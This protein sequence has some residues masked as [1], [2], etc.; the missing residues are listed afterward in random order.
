MLPPGQEPCDLLT[1]V[2]RNNSA[3]EHTGALVAFFAFEFRHSHA[4]V[5]D[6]RRSTA[7]AA[8]RRAPGPVH[9]RFTSTR[10]RLAFLFYFPQML[11]KV[12]CQWIAEKLFDRPLRH[13]SAHSRWT[14]SRG[15]SPCPAAP[16]SPPDSR[17]RGIR[18]NDQSLRLNEAES[19]SLSLRL[20]NL[21]ARGFSISGFP[22]RCSPASC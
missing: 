9:P 17:C 22:S 19:S 14:V 4:G 1:M 21:P 10:R 11:T 7:L 18:Q 16:S 12:R 13:C 8:L 3:G 2:G 15:P 20:M 6:R 5:A